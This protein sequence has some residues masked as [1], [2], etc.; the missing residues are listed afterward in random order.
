MQYPGEYISRATIE[1][2]VMVYNTYGIKTGTRK[3]LSHAFTVVFVCLVIAAI[4]PGVMGATEV[5]LGSAG[6]FAVLAKTAITDTGSASVISGDV[7]LGHPGTGAAIVGFD[8]CTPPSPP[9]RV[10]GTIYKVDDAGT[11][12]A[13]NNPTLADNAVGD[14]ILAYSNATLEPTDFPTLSGQDIGGRTLIPGAYSW[15]GAVTMSDD[16]TLDGQGD[17]NAVWIFKTTGY[18]TIADNK[19]IILLRGAQPKNIFWVP[20]DYAVLGAHSVFN[21]NILS[22]TAITINS[23]ATL[24]GRALAQSAVTMATSTV[25]VPVPRVAPVAAFTFTN[26]TGIEPLTVAFT[27]ASSADPTGS[28]SGWAWDFEN[29]GVIDSTARNPVYIYNTS[30]TFTPNLTVTDSFGSTASKIDTVTAYQSPIADFTFTPA[31]GG[32]AYLN[33]AFTD[34]SHAD[35]AATIVRWAWDFENDG[36]IDNTTRN[37]EYTY[38]SP[39]T[40]T[41]NLTVT[42]SLGGTATKLGSITVTPASL[43]ITVTNVP[44]TLAFNSG[45]IANSTAITFFVNSTTNWQVTAIDA[46]GTTLGYMTSY[47]GTGYNSAMKLSQPFMVRQNAGSNYVNL[48]KGSDLS[49][50]IQTGIPEISG[51]P[52]TLGVQQDITSA[53]QHLSGENVYRIVVTLTIASL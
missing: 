23:G 20:A 37:P 18:L 25:S 16:V 4:A 21:G 52:Y 46:D 38:I 34:T 5:D 13:T 17:A 48:P 14:M 51:T 9:L 15:T 2:T 49:T 7:G 50:L 36:I 12:C 40:Y 43:G 19:K 47:S 41:P 11:A 35:P 30:G 6:T 26:A 24:N 31:G 29:D 42:D 10:S 53:D 22:E 28:I 1:K 3:I 45:E 44:L 8:V 39:E 33:V 32:S 27:D